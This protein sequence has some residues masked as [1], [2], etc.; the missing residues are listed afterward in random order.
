M[1]RGVMNIDIMLCD[2]PLTVHLTR[3]AERALGERLTP[4]V[5]E[6]ELYFSCLIRKRV[7]FHSVV[8]GDRCVVVTGNLS[9]TFRTVMTEQ[10]N[11]DGSEGEDVTVT[12]FPLVKAA[13][14]IPRWLRID[15]RKGEW[16]G[17][18]GYL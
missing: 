15:Y 14:Y 16:L 5:A 6:M 7:R 3:A 2:K 17:E 10:C 13:A 18:F 11:L 4:L 12:E 8:R 9:V 1:A